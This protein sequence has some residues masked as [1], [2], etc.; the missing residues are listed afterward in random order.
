[1]AAHRHLWTAAASKPHTATMRRCGATVALLLFA[2][3]LWHGTAARG[4]GR[5]ADSGNLYPD[6]RLQEEDE[7]QPLLPKADSEPKA[8]AADDAV[9]ADM[10]Q[11][12]T[13]QNPAAVTAFATQ[14]AAGRAAGDDTAEPDESPAADAKQERAPVAVERP[15]IDDELAARQKAR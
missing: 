2:A 11:G 1:M 3:M 13:V 8:A 12:S 10:S 7:D 14:Q 15:P 4:L 5:A 9:T 6:R